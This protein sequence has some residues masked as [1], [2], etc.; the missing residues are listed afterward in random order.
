MSSTAIKHAELTRIIIVTPEKEENAKTKNIFITKLLVAKVVAPLA[1][2]A[3]TVA[4]V[5]RLC[6]IDE[7]DEDDTNE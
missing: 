5:N 3:V 6:K 7:T 2:V 1:I 4:V